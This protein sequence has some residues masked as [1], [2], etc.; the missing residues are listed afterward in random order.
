MSILLLPVS[1]VTSAFYFG[2]IASEI[3][4]C[5]FLLFMGCFGIPFF[6]YNNIVPKQ[7][8]FF[9]KRTSK[10]KQFRI[11]AFFLSYTFVSSVLT[12]PVRLFAIQGM[13]LCHCHFLCA[14]IGLFALYSSFDNRCHTV[15]Y[16]CLFLSHQ[17]FICRE[18]ILC[19]SF[20]PN[21]IIVSYIFLV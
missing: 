15:F 3:S 11:T 10:E 14:E 17:E 13:Q 20:N 9:R 2:V 8:V 19:V 1:R 6:C 16:S 7:A 12:F 21:G 18:Q 5:D 4:A